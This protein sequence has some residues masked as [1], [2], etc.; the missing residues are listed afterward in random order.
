MRLADLGAGVV[1][2]AGGMN[3]DACRRSEPTHS[4]T[5]NGA[6]SD[7]A[8]PSRPCRSADVDGFP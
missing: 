4:T 1:L 7:T 6:A 3:P 5:W 8:V 2:A